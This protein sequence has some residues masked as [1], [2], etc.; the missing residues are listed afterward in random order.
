MDANQDRNLCQLPI[1]EMCGAAQ[2]ENSD[3]IR[4]TILLSA[5]AYERMYEANPEAQPLRDQVRK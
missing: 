1:R 2:T 5:D 4:S 3:A